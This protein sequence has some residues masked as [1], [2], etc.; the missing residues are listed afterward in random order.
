MRPR[1]G[2]G[3]RFVPVAPID[4]WPLRPLPCETWSHASI[5]RTSLQGMFQH[6]D[7][8]SASRTRV[9]DAWKVGF[10]AESPSGGQAQVT[11][12]PAFLTSET[13]PGSDT[14][15]MA[16]DYKFGSPEPEYRE[17][18]YGNAWATEETTGGGNRLVIAPAHR[19][20][21]MLDALL[22]EMTGPFWLLYILV[23]PRGRAESGRYQS[24]ETA[25]PGSGGSFSERVLELP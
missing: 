1:R 25:N 21:E 4:Q 2:T 20:T 9:S 24:P 19:Q 3:T 7:F 23:I 15:L 18:A 11:E 8:G 17:W 22:K 14:Q 13:L 16:T 6:P 12:N 5:G 10:S